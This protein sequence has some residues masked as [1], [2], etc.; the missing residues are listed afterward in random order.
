MKFLHRKRKFRPGASNG[1][2]TLAALVMPT[3]GILSFV[4]DADLTVHRC[5]NEL[6]LP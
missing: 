4:D 3:S 2:A 1:K 6:V 5:Q